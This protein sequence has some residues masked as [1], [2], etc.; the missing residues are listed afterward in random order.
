M[1]LSNELDV[2]KKNQP[3]GSTENRNSENTHFPEGNYSQSIPTR[4]SP[5][6]VPYVE[7][8]SPTLRSNILQGKDINLASLIMPREVEEQ[9]VTDSEGRY[10]LLKQNQDARLLRNLTL[11]EFIIAF[12]K[13]KNIMCKVQ[14]D[15]N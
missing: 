2:L 14:D 7:T 9:R 6:S 10:I 3:C 5:D 1:K 4:V 15:R 11:N 12:S 8:V 13:Y